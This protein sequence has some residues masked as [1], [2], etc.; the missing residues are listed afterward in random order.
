MDSSPRFDKLT[1][2]A[3]FSLAALLLV[4]APAAADWPEFRGPTRDGVS[5]ATNVPIEW[6]ATENVV[7]KQPIP[8]SG[9][10]SPVLVDGKIYLTTATGTADAGDV[11]L[12]VI[13]VDAK[14]GRIL[15]DVEAIR[16]DVEAAKIM[17][18]KNSLAS[19]TPIVEG[20]RVFVHFGHMGTAALDLAGKIL[21]TQTEIHYSPQ[22]GTGGSPALVDDLL[23][24][25]CDGDE[26]PFVVALD[27]ETGAER[28]RVARESEADR[29]FSFCTPLVIE[30][31][32]AK[33]IISPGSGM[34]GAYDPHSGRELWRVNYDQGFSVVPR[35]VFAD[36]VLYLCSGFL[37]ANL[38]AVNPQGAAG[39]VTESNIAWKFDRG[40]PTTPS[41]LVAGD[42]IYFVSDGGVATCLDATS[43]DVQWTERLG[44]GFSASPVFA[45]GRI[46]F[47]NE[48][49]T[50][51]VV[52][53]GAECELLATNELGERALASP[54]VDDGAIY[55]RTASHLWRIGK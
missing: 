18:Q 28:W 22:P 50:T 34:A 47:T 53:A 10:S 11:S 38:L 36:G 1:R 27:R 26:D 39:D 12:R 29:K 35:P 20:D 14:D 8:G 16:P 48:D 44:G 33:Q 45:E 13:S 43:G 7:W 51:Y 30:V 23:A 46:Y 37:R 17:H 15:W 2:S 32:G 4:A 9:W 25:S 40:V 24:F 49:G 19:A 5:T 55:L 54:A 52:R 31:D 42:E 6:S 3:I 41:I 21:W